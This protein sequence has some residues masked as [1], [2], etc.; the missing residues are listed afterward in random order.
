MT[1]VAKIVNWGSCKTLS[2]VHAFLGM[3]GLMCI[4]IRNYSRIARPLTLLM[5]KGIEFHFG[6]EQIEAQ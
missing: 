2:E 4:F 3:A 5:H 1:K 6:P